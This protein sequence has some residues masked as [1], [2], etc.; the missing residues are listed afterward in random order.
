MKR[1]EK[2]SKKNIRQEKAKKVV[3]EMFNL[4][5]EDDSEFEEEIEDIHMLGTQEEGWARPLEFKFRSQT[6]AQDILSKA[7]KM[8]R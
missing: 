6:T 3:K 1:S 7:R 5:Q 4:I 8:Q 2:W